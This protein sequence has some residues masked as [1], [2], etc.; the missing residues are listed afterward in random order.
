MD[1]SLDA[2]AKR[3]EVHFIATQRVLREFPNVTSVVASF[4]TNFE[5]PSGPSNV[6]IPP[7]S[8]PQPATPA[9]AHMTMAEVFA[10][11]GPSTVH[12]PV[13]VPQPVTPPAVLVRKAFEN[14][15]TPVKEPA[16]DTADTADASPPGV[17]TPMRPLPRPTLPLLP[18]ETLKRKPAAEL[19]KHGFSVSTAGTE[20]LIQMLS[21]AAASTAEP[22][23]VPRIRGYPAGAAPAPSTAE[24]QP[25]PRRRCYP[26]G[27]APA[28]STA[29]QCP[30]SHAKPKRRPRGRGGKHNSN[31]QWHCMYH[32]ALSQGRAHLA[33]FL[34]TF[35]KPKKKRPMDPMG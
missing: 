34:I 27:A 22:Q 17:A 32:K 28:A 15:E 2:L 10:V 12:I 3:A 35:P 14:F 16:V 8:F 20:A 13:S 21:G 33:E 23:P 26:P 18:H 9:A 19:Q 11:V 1:S 7:C 30:F 24:P 31:V 4:T 29:R 6:H 5:K 25:V